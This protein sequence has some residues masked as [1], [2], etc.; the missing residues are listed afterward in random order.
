MPNI[1]Y[2]C[3]IDRQPLYCFQGMV[4]ASTLLE[5]AGVRP[6]AIVV[7]LIEGVPNAA[8]EAL[9]RLGVTVIT[10]KPFDR[11]HPH[12]NKLVQLESEALRAADYVILCDSDLAFAASL[13]PWVGGTKLLAKPVDYAKPNIEAWRKLMPLLGFKDDLPTVPATHSGEATYA[14]NFNGGLYIVPQPVLQRLRTAWPK[15]NRQLLERAE[16]LGPYRFHTDQISLA[17]A[18]AD[19]GE[20]G[21]P[22][23]LEMN[24]PTHLPLPEHARL[25]EAPR[26]LHYH[27][28]LDLAGRLLAMN[29]PLVDQAIERINATIVTRRILSGAGRLPLRMALAVSA[30]RRLLRR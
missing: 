14:N 3:V 7:H 15:W 25:R 5:L 16:L 18:L 21:D 29:V 22:L 2:S 26:V 13:D 1:M 27:T 4:F 10:T 28:R 20:I 12:S 11:R 9:G 19:L 6:E 30:L 8:R 17:V 23:P 24:L